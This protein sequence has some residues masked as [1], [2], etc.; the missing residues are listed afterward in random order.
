MNL[1]KLL[2]VSLLAGLYG[3]QPENATQQQTAPVEAMPAAS[4]PVSA[5]PAQAPVAQ[6]A[7]AVQPAPSAAVGVAPVIA[8]KTAKAVAPVK[9]FPAKV[10]AAPPVSK[11]AVPMKEKVAVVVTPKVATVVTVVPAAPVVV[12]KTEIAV[13]EADALALAKKSNCLACHAIDKKVVGPAWKEVAAKYRGDATAE[14]H[15]INKIA[16]GGSGVWGSMAMPAHPKLSEAERTTLAR[17]VL[18]LK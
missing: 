6:S 4:E 18:N 13:S 2:L 10:E 11:P 5:A 12:A 15:L 16:V 8:E 1:Q 3:C 9:A 14:A 17:F 7:S